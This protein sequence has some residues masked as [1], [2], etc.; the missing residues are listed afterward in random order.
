MT[1]TLRITPATIKDIPALVELVNSAYRGDAAR[2]GWTHEVDLISGTVRIDE[3]SLKEIIEKPHAVILKCTDA[4]DNLVGCV[5]LD[6]QADKLYLGMLSV[7]PNI[8][9]KGVGKRLL[10]AAEEYAYQHQI[11]RIVMTVIDVRKELIAWYERN[12][13]SDTGK[14]EPFPADGRFGMPKV[15]LEFAVLEKA[16]TKPQ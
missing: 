12:G 16:L 9:A 2:Q 11:Y 4:A 8:Q 13:Y 1:N 6:K 14:R 15:P 3:N 5:Y 7:S 10:Q